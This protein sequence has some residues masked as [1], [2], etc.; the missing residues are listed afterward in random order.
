MSNLAFIGRTID[1]LKNRYGVPIK[2]IQLGSLTVNY[3]TG[4]QE[5]V[6][7][8][9]DITKAIAMQTNEAR[10]LT[11]PRRLMDNVGMIDET[12]RVFIVSN[13]DLPGNFVLNQNDRLEYNGTRYDIKRIVDYDAEK[14]AVLIEC[15]AVEGLP[16]SN[17]SEESISQEVSASQEITNE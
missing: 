5:R 8:I 17:V 1:R 11:R 4:K 16:N 7:T 3:T 13:T 15:I 10:K 6:E 14:Q 9:I 12:N 2:I